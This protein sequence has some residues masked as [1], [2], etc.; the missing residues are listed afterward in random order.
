MK[1]AE[2]RLG[3]HVL[4][5]DVIFAE[6]FM[7]NTEHYFLNRCHLNLVLALM[8]FNESSS[9]VLHGFYN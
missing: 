2:I 7:I 1:I 9:N 8:L 4:A 5:S 6:Q 3:K